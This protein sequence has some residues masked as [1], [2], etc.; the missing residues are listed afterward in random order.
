MNFCNDGSHCSRGATKRLGTLERSKLVIS[1][2]QLARGCQ[3]EWRERHS[4]ATDLSNRGAIFECD[5]P[6]IS[7]RTTTTPHLDSGLIAAKDNLTSLTW[8][9]LFLPKTTSHLP[10][11]QQEQPATETGI[12]RS[13]YRLVTMSSSMDLDAP[14][15]MMANAGSAGTHAT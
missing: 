15:P 12:S 11:P 7:R 8:P 9:A 1:S 3:A 6:K 14:V 10:S 2:C 13:L 5:F 4:N